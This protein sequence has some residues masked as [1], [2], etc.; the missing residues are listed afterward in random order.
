MTADDRE[1]VAEWQLQHRVEKMSSPA[2]VY[3]TDGRLCEAGKH[4]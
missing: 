4:L 3:P 2:T 1:T